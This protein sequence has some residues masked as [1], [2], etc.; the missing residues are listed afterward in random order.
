[1]K[2]RLLALLALCCSLHGHGQNWRATNLCSVPYLPVVMEA[3]NDHMYGTLFN[4]VTA[5]LEKLNTDHT[6]WDT[7][8]T[9]AEITVP[10]FMKIVGPRLYISTVNS[11]V[12]SMMYYTTDGGSTYI[13]DTAGLPHYISGVSLIG[14]VQHHK[15]RVFVAMSGNGYYMKDTASAT[16]HSINV[17]TMLNAPLD[18]LTFF[19]DTLYAYDNSGANAFYYST[20]WGTTWTARTSNL[21]SDYGTHVLVADEVSGRLYSGGAWNANTEYGLKYSDNGGI[22]WTTST[23]AAAFLGHT[24]SGALQTITAIY[25]HNPT[26]YLAMDNNKDASAPDIVGSFTGLANLAYDTL[27]LPTNAASNVNGINFQMY[28][29]KLALNLNVIDVYLKEGTTTIN[30]QHTASGFN[31]YP[32]PCHDYLML[33]DNTGAPV[34]ARIIDYT[35]RE[36]WSS[37]FPV[38]EANV[39]HLQNGIYLVELIVDGH[40]TGTKTFI[41][42]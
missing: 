42:E 4:S 30:E 34:M 21:P 10:R 11:G 27:G 41:K 14:R 12:Y 5:T 15:G 32:N 40:V 8:T 24:A 35:G 39:S 20:D 17:P 37:V 7:I 28:Q 31:I 26:V 9:S 1:M 19:G 13:T 36:V 16:W 6:S 22:T 3:D 33:S 29:G 38:R 2:T 23:E 18:P 25:A